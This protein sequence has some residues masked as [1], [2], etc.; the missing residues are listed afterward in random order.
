MTTH[1]LAPC[2]MAAALL[3]ASPGAHAQIVDSDAGSAWTRAGSRAYLGLNAKTAPQRLG[4]LAAAWGC[5]AANSVSLHGGTLFGGSWG[6]EVGVVDMGRAW[7][8]AW[9]A[10]SQGLNLSLVGRAPLGASFG[11][12]GRFGATY[13]LPEASPLPSAWASGPDGG[14]G[15]SYGG[16]LSYDFSPRLSATLGWDSHDG[17]LYGR[18]PVR[19]A[20]V[21]LQYR[22]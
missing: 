2:L 18:E 5:T 14:F 9:P 1:R 21:G 4:C 16:G 3:A 11:L 17:R 6:A 20:S 22:Y 7:R 12:F 15:L 8:S 13:G 19:A 10:R